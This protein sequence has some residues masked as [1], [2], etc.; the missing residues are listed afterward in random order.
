M[1]CNPNR[2]VSL[3]T[4]V[5][6]TNLSKNSCSFILMEISVVRPQTCSFVPE[7]PWRCG[8]SLGPFW[9]F[10]PSL[11]ARSCDIIFKAEPVSKVHLTSKLFILQSIL[12]WSLVLILLTTNFVIVS[13][14]AMAPN[15]GRAA[16]FCSLNY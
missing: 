8:A 4:F 9:Y 11:S 5:I 14:T 3:L 6:T 1:N 13:P 2:S 7:T 16:G 12:G 10:N 15:C